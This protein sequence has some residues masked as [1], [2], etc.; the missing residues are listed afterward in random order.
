MELQELTKKVCSISKE[1]GVFI[2]NESTKLN[3]EDI[4]VKSKN[5][6]VSYVDKTA[7]KE[8]VNFLSVLIPEA[9][10]IA[11]ERTS[12]KT[13]KVYNWII[14][15]LDGTTNFIHGIPTYCISIALLKNKELI[16]GV[17]Y[18]PNQDE[19]F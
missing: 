5:S 17:I 10:F 2:Q 16:L 7:E 18:E 9:G 8:L 12:D 13:G 3:S 14:D 1:V 15:P 11:E 6:L 4:E 19:I